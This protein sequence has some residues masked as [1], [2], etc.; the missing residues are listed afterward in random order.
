MDLELSG[1]TALVVGGASGLGAAIVEVLAEEGADVALT[2]HRS[3]RSAAQLT[4]RVRQHGRRAWAVPLDLADPGLSDPDPGSDAGSD[5]G[6]GPLEAVGD[7]DVLVCNA[8]RNVITPFDRISAREWREVLEVNLTGVFRVV[9]ALAPRLRDGAGIVTVASVAAHTGAPHHMHY[10]AAK[11]GL[12]NLTKSLARELAPRVRV[13]CVAPGI[14]RTP[15]G[16]Q[17][18]D[19]LPDGYERTNLLLQRFATPRRVAQ[20]V[21]V[22]A[23]PVS[24]HLTGATLDVNSGRYLR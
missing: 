5:A 20:L 24:A 14:I 8:G 4:E 9:Q 18:I 17:A 21:A 22:L 1:K 12:V 11:A 19:S 3:A 10:A 15:M 13:N 2:Y 6:L 23:S 7:L 16:Q